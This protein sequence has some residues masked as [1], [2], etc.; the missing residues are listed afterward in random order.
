MKN[1]YTRETKDKAK[2]LFIQ[3]GYFAH[4]ARE[5]GC[6][7]ETVSNNGIQMRPIS[8][9]SHNPSSGE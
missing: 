2:A 1:I 9:F 4:I 7:A 3:G 5:I 8:F 6:N